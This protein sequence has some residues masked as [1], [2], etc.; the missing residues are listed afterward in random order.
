MNRSIT[1]AIRLVKAIV[2]ISAVA[3]MTIPVARAT[4]T[5]QYGPLDPW[6]YNV[7]HRSTPSIPLITEHSAG[8]KGVKSYAG[9]KYGPLD[10]WAYNVIR[11]GASPIPLVTEHSA[12]Q[13]S[14]AEPSTGHVNPGSASV[15][16][17][18][19]NWRDAGIGATST[20]ALVMLVASAIAVRR[21]RAVAHVRF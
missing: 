21:R 5:D 7:I 17:N 13:N 14:T 16:P 20:L 18:G 1:T 9:A 6:A 19:F 3:V 4:P 2:V 15:E 11:R 8:Q 10:P 12:G